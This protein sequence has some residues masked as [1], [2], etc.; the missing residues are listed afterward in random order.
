MPILELSLNSA[1]NTTIRCKICKEMVEITKMHV[2]IRTCNTCMRQWIIKIRDCDV[3]KLW[4][5]IKYGTEENNNQ[6]LC[7]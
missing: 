3:H 2:Q 5:E 1:G 7:N 6:E 4:E